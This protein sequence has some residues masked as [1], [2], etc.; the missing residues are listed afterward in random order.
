MFLETELSLVA[1][2]EIKKLNFSSLRSP[3]FFL[4]TVFIP[5]NMTVILSK[6]IVCLLLYFISQYCIS[7]VA[8]CFKSSICTV[9]QYFTRQVYQ[10]KH[11]H[12]TPERN[13]GNFLSIDSKNNSIMNILIQVFCMHCIHMHASLWVTLRVERLA[14]LVLKFLSFFYWFAYF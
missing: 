2:T 8:C 5:P 1:S 10:N 13:L 14:H 12:F 4:I 3:Y 11:I 6:S 7:I 9:V